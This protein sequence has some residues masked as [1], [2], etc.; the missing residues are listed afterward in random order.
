M[1]KDDPWILVAVAD[2]GL[3]CQ[4]KPLLPGLRPALFAATVEGA[5]DILHHNPVAAVVADP[6]LFPPLK[7]ENRPDLQAVMV[8]NGDRVPPAFPAKA[9]ALV[10]VKAADARRVLHRAL[11]PPDAGNRPVPACGEMVG[12]SV[13]MRQVFARIR[14]I[15]HSDS[16]VLIHGETGTGKELAARAIHRYGA[17]RRGPFIVF[18]GADSSPGL[19]ESDLFGH[20]RGA[21]T[22]ACRD[23]R[24]RLEAADGGTLLLDDI[25]TLNCD[26]QAKLLRVLQD[27]KFQRLGSERPMRVDVRFIAAT[28]R[29]P[30]EM[31]ASGALRQDLYYRLNVLPLWLPPLRERGA[32]VALLT[33]YFTAQWSERTVLRPRPITRTVRR[34]LAGHRWPGN[35]RELR[36]AVER[37]HTLCDSGSGDVQALRD[38]VI[39]E[40]PEAPIGSLRAERI[41]FEGRL[42]S[43]VLTK[44]A[45]NRNRAAAILGI[46]RNT[47]RDKM[48][49]VGLASPRRS[50]KT[51][52]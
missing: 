8:F 23:R 45:G 17:R 16:N 51:G 14:R 31:L 50:R 6:L 52:G 41:K 26:L 29:D 13:V 12:S 15:A 11:A 25:D 33:D 44:T 47:L 36:N 28:N 38:A 19:M 49:A 9:V 32:D 34:L 42:I 2:A 35:V 18:H 27:R 22:G 40:P 20:C 10:P 3:R 46:H 30:R 39:G 1:A 7:L 37:L 5:R 24:G 43:R 48:M 4:L 21:Y